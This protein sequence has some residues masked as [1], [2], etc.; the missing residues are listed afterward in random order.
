MSWAI[1]IDLGGT[2]VKAVAVKEDGSIIHRQQQPTQDGPGMVDRWVEHV[3]HILQD[4][5]MKAG[6]PPKSIGVCSPGLAAADE[7]SIAWLP[8]KLEGLEGFDWTAA[9]ESQR[10]VPVVNDA[11]AALLGEAW[12]GAARDRSN[13]VLLTLGTGVGGAILNDGKL[14]RGT[15]GR[16]G[17]LGH[18]CLDPSGT[19]SITGMP[20]AIEVMIGDCTVSDRS[21][22]RFS[23]TEALVRAHRD[24]DEEA[25]SIWHKSVRALGCAIGSYINIIDPEIVVL[26]GGI[27]AAGDALLNPLDAV[28][29][30]IEWRPGAYSVPVVLATLGEWAG[31]LGAARYGLM[32]AK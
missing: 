24:G 11:H 8:G 28:L 14:L 27:A 1:G 9:L 5:E 22:G 15:I 4:F 16:G 25:T 3:R 18:M 29:Y 12:V 17:H 6:S 32:H 10:L 7:R 23:S 26:A 19:P 30:E 21:G 20:G 2:I 13:V 31:A